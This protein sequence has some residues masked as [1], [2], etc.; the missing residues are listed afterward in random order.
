MEF[1]FCLNITLYLKVILIELN[2]LFVLERPLDSART[3]LPVSSTQLSRVF[4][5]VA[6]NLRRCATWLGSPGLSMLARGLRHPHTPSCPPVPS[7][8]V[9]GTIVK[10]VTEYILGHV[11]GCFCTPLLCSRR[12]LYD[13]QKITVPYNNSLIVHQVIYLKNCLMMFVYICNYIAYFLIRA[14]GRERGWCL[15]CTVLA[16]LPRGLSRTLE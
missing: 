16:L 2:F 11:S 14:Y 12:I 15:E 13:D 6:W 1:Y 7:A 5:T 9:I 3:M 8:S 10:F 4:R